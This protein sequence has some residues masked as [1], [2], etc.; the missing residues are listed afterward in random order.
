LTDLWKLVPF[1]IISFV[2]LITVLKL[3]T[4][5]I[6]L[7]QGLKKVDWLGITT[8]VG[9]ALMLLLGLQIGATKA[10]W[11]SALV[12]LLITF[13]LLGFILF[14]IIEWK[15]SKPPLMP[16]KFFT[17]IS[18]T[19]TLGVNVAQSFIT[20]G[21]TY[22]L[23]LYFQLVLHASPTMSG[24][25]FL[26]TTLVLAVFFV[27]VGYVVRRTGE[28]R[29]LIQVGAAALLLSTG[30]FIRLGPYTDWPLIILAQIT[31]GIGLGLTYQAPLIAF[32]AQIEESEV[33]AGTSIFQ[34]LKTLTQAVSV[35]FGQVIFQSQCH[36]Q[37][38][39]IQQ[40]D[41]P[42]SLTGSLSAGNVI[43]AGPSILEL[44]DKQQALVRAVLSRAFDR[45]WIF[46]TIIAFLGLLCSFG[47]KKVKL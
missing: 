6:P 27:F 31:I 33:A 29:I 10:S 7:V 34:F 13:G 16:L 35:I 14:A 18:T 26:P 9:A 17:T 3:N 45:M 23:P 36:S 24:V 19:F 5:K 39:T 40:A 32:H 2:V 4:S 12:I 21:C 22:F 46:Y 28:Y 37:L 47:I 11:S 20:T 41:L 30:L 15:I 25:Y 43:S 1:N 44:D 42:K 8:I 38:G